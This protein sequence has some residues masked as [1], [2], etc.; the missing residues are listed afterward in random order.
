MCYFF[1]LY[2]KIQKTPTFGF[3][4]EWIRLLDFLYHKNLH[5]SGGQTP[6]FMVGVAAF[7]NFY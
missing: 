5:E 4:D 6:P 2:N 1:F 7:L 3:G